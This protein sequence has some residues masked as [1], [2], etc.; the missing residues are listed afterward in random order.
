[1]Q[2]L[3]ETI[4]NKKQTVEALKKEGQQL[5]KTV[6]TNDAYIKIANS[7]AKTNTKKKN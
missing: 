4:N 5:N 2:T 7:I 6:A 3:D 1:V